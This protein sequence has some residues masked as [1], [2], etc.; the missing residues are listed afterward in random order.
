MQ[1]DEEETLR[2]EAVN[3]HIDDLTTHD[4]ALFGRLR[5][6]PPPRISTFRFCAPSKF[7]AG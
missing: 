2:D 1:L 3:V 6:K 5:S 7:R 4:A